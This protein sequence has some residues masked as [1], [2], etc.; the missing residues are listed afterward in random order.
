MLTDE[1][2]ID[3]EKVA[4]EHIIVATVLRKYDELMSDPSVGFRKA[5]RGTVEKLTGELEDINKDESA[6]LTDDKDEKRFERIMVIFKE[7]AKI[8]EAVRPPQFAE[9]ESVDGD[10]EVKL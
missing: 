8:V 5:I 2:R 10:T 1:E 4:E 7:N 6:I 3:I 9:D